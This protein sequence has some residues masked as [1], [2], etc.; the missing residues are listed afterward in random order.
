MAHIFSP[1]TSA[2]SSL[3]SERAELPA[4][5]QCPIWKCTRLPFPR[6]S[7]WVSDTLKRAFGRWFG[8]PP[9]SEPNPF[10]RGKQ[11]WFFGEIGRQTKVASFLKVKKLVCLFC[12]FLSEREKDITK[13]W[14]VLS[15]RR[16]ANW[17]NLCSPCFMFYRLCNTGE[18][19]VFYESVLLI[20]LVA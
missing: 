10:R 4:V 18:S 6:R 9:R 15:L 14:A 16:Y 5:P 11:F 2:K 17:P 7:D 8:R 20:M 13:N 3:S 1:E 12:L 19:R